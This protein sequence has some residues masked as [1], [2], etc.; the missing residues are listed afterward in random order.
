MPRKNNLRL[1]LL[2]R[3]LFHVAGAYCWHQI[4]YEVYRRCRNDII[5][6]MLPEQES[7]KWP[8]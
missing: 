7:L 4:S 3:V 2:S 6:L 5:R 1:L 8:N